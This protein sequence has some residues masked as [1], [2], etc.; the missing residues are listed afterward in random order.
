MSGA[1]DLP[2]PA[3]EEPPSPR[4]AAV[5]T[6][7][8]SIPGVVS[9]IAF[10]TFFS[11]RFEHSVELFMSAVMVGWL[12]HALS[13]LGLAFVFVAAWAHLPR[14]LILVIFAM[15]SSTLAFLCGGD[16]WSRVFS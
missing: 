7:L 5:F 9:W 1:K 6:V 12:L 2:F 10:V 8:F 15:N 14:R 13:V 11:T 4:E 3:I 16:L